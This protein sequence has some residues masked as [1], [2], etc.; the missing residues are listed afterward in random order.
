MQHGF[1][2]HLHN[3]RFQEREVS[4]FASGKIED[5]KKLTLLEVT[6]WRALVLVAVFG[7][8]QL[9][10][11]RLIDEFWISNPYDIFTR[12]W[13]LATSGMLWIHSW[14]TLWQALLGLMLA[15]PIGIALGIFLVA[16]PR[17]AVAVDP[18]LMG[19]YSLPRIALAPLFVIWFGIG[20]MSKVMLVFSLVVFVFVLNTRQGLLEVDRDLISLMKTMRAT[21]RYIFRRVQM[22]SILPWLIAAFR[23]NVGLALIGSVIGELLGSNRGLGWYIEHSGGRLD[24]T[25]V[26]AGL[27]ALM[28]LALLINEAVSAVERKVLRFQKRV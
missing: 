13:Q 21:R 24:T 27:I 17:T 3:P 1:K 11:G 4:Q 23:I 12:L 9:V 25:G 20:L 26:F 14:A 19:L 15:L 7:L 5:V 6:F 16:F 10:S 22:P 8:W 18:Y 28:V 2:S